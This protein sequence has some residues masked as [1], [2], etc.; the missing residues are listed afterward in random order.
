MHRGKQAGFG[1]GLLDELEELFDDSLPLL[2]FLLPDSDL[3]LDIFGLELRLLCEE[4]D[5]KGDLGRLDSYAEFG[6]VLGIENAV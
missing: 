4:G 2:S 3:L 5:E 6:D 1:S